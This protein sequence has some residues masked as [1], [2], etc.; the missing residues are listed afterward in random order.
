[1][2][3][4][5]PHFI[6]GVKFWCIGWKLLDFDGG[7]PVKECAHEFGA[8]YRASV[9]HESYWPG[10]SVADLIYE[11]NNGVGAEMCIVI[12]TLMEKVKMLSGGADRNCTSHGD[13]AMR[14]RNFDNR[15][16]SARCE[17]PANGRR[18]Q[19]SGLVKKNKVCTSLPNLGD[20]PRKFRFD[21][22]FN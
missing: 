8:V 16:L 4:V 6:Y 2:F 12:Q 21:P 15:W 17:R 18:E 1:M 19:E 13:A 7:V 3:K 10:K 14:L 9:A 22:A 11:L 5:S 20:N